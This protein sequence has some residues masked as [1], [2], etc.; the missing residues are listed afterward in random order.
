MPTRGGNAISPMRLALLALAATVAM[1]P[2]A[3]LA[4]QA[5]RA[6]D[7]AMPAELAEAVSAYR[8]ATMQ[9][10]T[11]TL[12]TLVADDYI[13]VNSDSSLQAKQSYLDDFK[14]P[15]FKVDRYVVEQPVQTVWGDTAL[16]RGLLHLAWTQ[17]GER[18]GRMLRLAHVW[19]RRDGHWR[20][21]YTQLTRVPDR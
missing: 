20:I 4:A 12:S 9:G 8:Q 13:L 5:S 6:G 11:A 3:T 1:L 18:H 19:T 16:V 14:V 15:G 10:D 7:A 21:A 2:S 17:D